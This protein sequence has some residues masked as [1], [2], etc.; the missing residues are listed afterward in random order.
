MSY[1]L[2]PELVTVMAA[3]AEQS[4]GAAP[5]RGS[6]GPAAAV[7]AGVRGDPATFGMLIRFFFSRTATY[8]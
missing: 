7:I 5:V 4:A 6:E 1:P 3:L 2:D 8:V